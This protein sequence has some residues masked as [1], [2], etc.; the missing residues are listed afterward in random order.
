MDLEIS[1]TMLRLRNSLE[2]LRKAGMLTVMVYCSGSLQ[3]TVS[4]GEGTRV[5]PKRRHKD[6]LNSPNPAV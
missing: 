5:K 2:E 1:K 6:T 4:K 3:V